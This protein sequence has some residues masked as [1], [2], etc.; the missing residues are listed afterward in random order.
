MVHCTLG[1]R[2]LEWL[3]ELSTC[4]Q[5]FN[6]NRPIYT[7]QCT[8]VKV[9]DTPVPLA[10]TFLDCLPLFSTWLWPLAPFLYPAG[11]R[12]FGLGVLFLGPWRI[13]SNS[14][15]LLLTVST[16]LAL[17]LNFPCDHT[18]AYVWAPVS[19]P[20]SKFYFPTWRIGRKW[21]SQLLQPEDS[22]WA[23]PGRV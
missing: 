21:M 12:P 15:S 23:L 16:G 1:N 19:P 6:L 7:G 10:S 13:W 3:L 17:T 9:L 4:N 5:W 20:L 18:P 14:V 8:S 2:I 22:Y 11:L